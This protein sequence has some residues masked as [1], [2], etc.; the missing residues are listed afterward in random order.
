M[1]ANC[2]DRIRDNSVILNLPVA[3]LTVGARAIEVPRDLILAA[4]CRDLTRRLKLHAQLLL[5][6]PVVRLFTSEKGQSA[7]ALLDIFGEA[8]FVGNGCLP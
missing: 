7:A 4:P 5:V 8:R 1:V 6:R 2:D 3:L